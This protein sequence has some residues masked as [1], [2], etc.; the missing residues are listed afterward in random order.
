[1]TELEKALVEIEGLQRRI[2]EAEKSRGALIKE[3]THF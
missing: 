2:A 3:R 1:M